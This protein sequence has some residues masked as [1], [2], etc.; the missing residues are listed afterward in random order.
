MTELTNDA[1][2][3]ETRPDLIWDDEARGLCVRVCS[4]ASKS[5]IFVYR[6]GY[7]QRF[8]RIG[9]SPKWSLEAARARAKEL[10][11]I[12]DQGRDPAADEGDH[13]GIARVEEFL[14]YI[15]DGK[16]RSTNEKTDPPSERDREAD[17]T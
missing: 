9:G 2:E 6:I 17:T 14:R 13:P 11:R 15:S 12:V 1:A 3:V 7:R 4:D 10:R 16:V 5:F 8:I